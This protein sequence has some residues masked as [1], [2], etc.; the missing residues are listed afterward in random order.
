MKNI[1]I[2]LL[3]RI[4]KFQ[5]N[6]YSTLDNRINK[7]G[8]SNLNLWDCNSVEKKIIRIKIKNASCQYKLFIKN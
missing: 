2:L 7:I 3:K 6:L 1:I 8:S 5:Y 4:N